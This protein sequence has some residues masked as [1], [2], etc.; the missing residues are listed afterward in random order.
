M[1][2][3]QGIK[4]IDKS[5]DYQNLTIYGFPSDGLII[6][7]L[8]LFLCEDDPEGQTEPAIEVSADDSEVELNEKTVDYPN[9]S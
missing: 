3:R 2:R 7:D 5:I 4:K 1:R 8:A 9:Q 6:R